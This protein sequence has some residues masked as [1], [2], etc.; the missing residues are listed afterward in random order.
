MTVKQLK[1]IEAEL[2]R[3]GYKKYTTHLTSTESWAWFKSFGV[4]KDE[5]GEIVNGYQ[6]AFRVWDFS[7]Y[8]YRDKNMQPYGLDFWTSAFGTDNRMDFTSNWEP[9]CNID[10][11]EKMAAEFNKLVKKYATTSKTEKDGK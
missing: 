4:E 11:F 1:K 3:H 9:I 7:R 5:D 2:E 6:I 10:T 8:I